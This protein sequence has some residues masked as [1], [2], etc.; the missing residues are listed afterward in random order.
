MKSD[1]FAFSTETPPATASVVCQSA[2]TW[3]DQEWLS[4]RCN[5][6]QLGSPLSIYECHLGSWRRQGDKGKKSRS[7]SYLELAETL[8]PYVA[9]MG[10]THVEFLPVAEHPF[11]GSW[12]YQVQGIMRRLHGMDRPTSFGISST[13]FIEAEWVS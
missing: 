11:G 6:D 9:D 1:P 7:L 2:Y 4:S 12:G 13:N 5:R 3:T 8:P 10:F